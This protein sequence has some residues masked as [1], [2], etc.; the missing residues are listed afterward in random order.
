MLP[1]LS[2]TRFEGAQR[3]RAREI[4]PNRMPENSLNP[5][6][7]VIDGT[8]DGTVKPHMYRNRHSTE[9]FEALHVRTYVHV[10]ESLREFSVD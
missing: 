2:D 5:S 7:F 6:F 10:V 3:M 9:V 4:E 1:K 8:H